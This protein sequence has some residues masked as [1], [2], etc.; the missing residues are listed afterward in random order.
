MDRRGFLR[1]LIGGVAAGAAVR[2]FPFRVFSFPTEI[3]VPEPILP[4]ELAMIYYDRQALRIL[5]ENL[6]FKAVIQPRPLPQWELPGSKVRWQQ[7]QWKT[8]I[9]RPN[10]DS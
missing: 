1:S 5:A 9:P 2:T 4:A 6:T 10:L 7:F 8:P 3:V